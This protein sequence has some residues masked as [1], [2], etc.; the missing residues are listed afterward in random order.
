MDGMSDRQIKLVVGLGNPG[1]EYEKTRHNAGFEVTSA[2]VSSLPGNFNR[3]EKFNSV[4]WEGRFRGRNIIVQHPHTFMNLSGK[5]VAALA[6]KNEILPSE[7]IVVYDDMDL[8]LGKIRMRKNGSSAGHR[9]VESL[10]EELGSTKFPR[11]RIGIG[12]AQNGTIDH[13][14][15]AF[16]EDEQMIFDKVVKTCVDALTL[17][18]V[19]GVGNAM[20]KFNSI[21]HEPDSSNESKESKENKENKENNNQQ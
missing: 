10:I 6:R 18:L 12:R 11:L 4:Y 16:S 7:I 15:S 17:S 20:N 14:L 5:A 1:N 21:S 19:R 9:G 8:P 2:L 13:V 3:K